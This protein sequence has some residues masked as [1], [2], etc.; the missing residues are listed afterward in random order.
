M[1]IKAVQHRLL[2]LLKIAKSFLIY[3]EEI[4]VA[5]DAGHSRWCA[6]RIVKA[7]REVGLTPGDLKLCILTHRHWD[8]SGGVRALKEM[9][10]CEV[11]IHEGD[12]EALGNVIDHRLR[13]GEVIP[14]LGG[15][16]V[17]HVPGHTPGSICLLQG[18]SL[19]VG[20][21]L[22]GGRRGLKPPASIYCDDYEEA[23]RSLER[24][25]GLDFEAVYVSHGVDRVKGGKEALIEL[26][27]RLGSAS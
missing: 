26:L 27:N 3:D 8:H 2:G 14:L 16:R 6:K 12:A 17:I 25:R 4:A 1:M 5:V 15:I 10:G 18:D 19:I 20:D 11:A 7:L 21:A 13:D 24:L 9:T 22:I 23:L